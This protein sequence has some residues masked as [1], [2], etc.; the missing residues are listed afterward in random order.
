MAK[1]KFKTG[2]VEIPGDLSDRTKQKVRISIMLDGDLLDA[3]KAHAKE[4]DEKYQPLVNQTLRDIFL[5]DA[6]EELS[7]EI[8]NV[9]AFLAQ[10]REDY[11][12]RAEF[13]ARFLG[14]GVPQRPLAED[15]KDAQKSRMPLIG[16]L[17][18][19][20]KSRHG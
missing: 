6:D 16:A 1:K 2:T 5:G 10:L 14:A 13:R 17:Q 3:I 12:R 9:R 7:E 18:R 11:D 19:K 15:W 8:E 4:H 20:S